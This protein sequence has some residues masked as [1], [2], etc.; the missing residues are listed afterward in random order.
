MHGVL[1]FPFASAALCFCVAAQ[2]D[3]LNGDTINIQCFPDPSFFT[4]PITPFASSDLQQIIASINDSN[5]GL[6]GGSANNVNEFQFDLNSDNTN[7]ARIIDFQTARVCIELTDSENVFGQSLS[8]ADAVELL[9]G[10]VTKCCQDQT[11][12][13]VGGF[14]NVVGLGGGSAPGTINMAIQNVEDGI[15][16]ACTAGGEILCKMQRTFGEG[17]LTDLIT[18]P[19]QLGIWR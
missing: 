16:H 3:P 8:F 12:P 7:L 5:I 14:T 13:C 9:T 10:F 6:V 18:R 1:I 15:A 17:E 11:V 2:A 4:D 19:P